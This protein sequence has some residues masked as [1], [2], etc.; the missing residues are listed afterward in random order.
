VSVGG[1]A[2]VSAAGAVTL[3]AVVATAA[4]VV[5]GAGS[6]AAGSSVFFSSLNDEM[7]LQLQTSSAPLTHTIQ[8]F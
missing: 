2:A 7:V 3:G 1:G 8:L 6:A 4:A 5:F